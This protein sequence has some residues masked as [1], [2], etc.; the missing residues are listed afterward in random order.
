MDVFEPEP[1]AAR[2]IR[3]L[4]PEGALQRLQSLQTMMTILLLLR[5]SCKSV[6]LL[7]TGV[8]GVTGAGF[9]SWPDG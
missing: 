3:P 5:G 9:V 2:Q 8:I 4:T 1:R 6:T 7:Y